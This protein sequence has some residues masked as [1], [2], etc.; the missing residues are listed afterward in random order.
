[1]RMVRPWCAAVAAAALAACVPRT[2]PPAPAAMPAPV[3]VPPPPAPAPAPAPPAAW[4]DGPLSPGDW[5]Y[6]TDSGPGVAVFEQNG[7]GIFVVLCAQ[8]RRISL[9]RMGVAGGAPLIVRT[10]FGERALPTP[11]FVPEANATLAA[12]DPLLDQ[13]AFSR[14]RFL[15]RFEGAADLVLPTWPEPARAIEQCRG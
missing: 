5:T 14:G 9:V 1:M 7:L 2:A 6:N 13:I 4:E 10:S 12:S 3:P 15:V 8:D 11:G